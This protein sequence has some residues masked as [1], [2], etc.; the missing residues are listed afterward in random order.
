MMDES[1]TTT[2]V[3]GVFKHSVSK[4]LAV[5]WSPAPIEHNEAHCAAAKQLVGERTPACSSNRQIRRSRTAQGSA[6]TYCTTEVGA[7]TSSVEIT[8]RRRRAIQLMRSSASPPPGTVPW[9]SG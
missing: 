7:K 2:V 3:L 5:N 6:A 8:I 9:R 4:K 1:L